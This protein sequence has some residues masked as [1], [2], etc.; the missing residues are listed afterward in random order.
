MNL[1]LA[2]LNDGWMGRIVHAF[3]ETFDNELKCIFMRIK[4][5]T[6]DVFGICS[7]GWLLSLLQRRI[8]M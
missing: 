6:K 1:V 2:L 4:I 3:D 8:L 7:S 5:L